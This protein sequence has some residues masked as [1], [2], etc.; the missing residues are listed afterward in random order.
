[1]NKFYNEFTKSDLTTESFLPHSQVYKETKKNSG[2]LSAIGPKGNNGLPNKN[3][4]HKKTTA[5]S[6][7][8][9]EYN[10]KNKNKI[11]SYDETDLEQLNEEGINKYSFRKRRNRVIIIILIILLLLSMAF[12]V[13]Y[14]SVLRAKNN[15]FMHINSTS[16]ANVS[17][18]GLS[19]TEFRCPT[20]L[21]GDRI[22]KL[23]MVAEFEAPGKY[24]IEYYF[25]CFES[26]KEMSNVL[27]FEPNLSY[28]RS[29]KGVYSGQVEI[30]NEDFNNNLRSVSLCNGVILDERYE[31]T[32]NA[33][34]FKMDFYVSIQQ[35]D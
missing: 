20:I 5:K 12:T 9:I 6:S 3:I 15:C 25:K 17:V 26:G 8:P 19:L 18:D 34:N 35:A 4:V 16:T 33:K 31:Y 22:L 24:N 27:V 10:P 13:V 32:L 28:F 29:N 2:G 14:A 30:T 11:D 23:E 21:Q 1:M 7:F